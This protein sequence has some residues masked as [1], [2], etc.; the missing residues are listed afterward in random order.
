LGN[1]FPSV[2]LNKHGSI[3]LEVLDRDCESEVVQK[4]ELKLEMVELS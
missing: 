3:S 1:N 4:K 2:E